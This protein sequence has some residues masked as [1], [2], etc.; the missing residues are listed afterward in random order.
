M[1]MQTALSYNFWKND[2]QAGVY[3]FFQHQYNYFNN[4]YTD[5]TPNVPASSIGV[6]GGVVDEF[7]NDKFKITPWFTLITGLRLSQFNASISEN[8]TDPRVG[9]GVEDS[10]PE[11]DR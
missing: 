9:G 7:I 11:L 10:P 8:A 5:G 2:L 4:V 3:G 6:N 1:G